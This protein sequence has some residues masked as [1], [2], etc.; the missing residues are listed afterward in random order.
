MGANPRIRPVAPVFA[1]LAL[2]ASAPVASAQSGSSSQTLSGLNAGYGRT[3]GQ[4]NRPVNPRTR[5]GGYNRVIVDG[6]ILTDETSVSARA[7]ALADAQAGVGGGGT[8]IGNQL[9]V[10]VQGSWNTVVVTSTQVNTGVVTAVSSSAARPP[11]A[12]PASP[13]SAQAPAQA[14]TPAPAQAPAEGELNGA[15]VMDFLP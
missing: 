11:E 7:R 2:V 1:C 4:E 3:P 14:P 8:A 15:L 10:V 9:N 12:A 6:V 13:S 5:D